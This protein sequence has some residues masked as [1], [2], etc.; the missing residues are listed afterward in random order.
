MRQVA[1]TDLRL[2]LTCCRVEET[3]YKGFEVD[4]RVYRDDDL[5]FYLFAL[6][7]LSLLVCLYAGSWPIPSILRELA[8]DQTR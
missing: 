6:D 2:S 1:G 5:R 7:V 3:C 8:A 4:N